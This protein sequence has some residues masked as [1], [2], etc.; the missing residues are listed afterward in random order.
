MEQY[1]IDLQAFAVNI[2]KH[3]IETQS[4]I[5]HK[6]IWLSIGKV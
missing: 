5:D 6:L 4:I 2:Q 3:D 1:N